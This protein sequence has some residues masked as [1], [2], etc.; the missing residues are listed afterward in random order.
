MVNVFFNNSTMELENK[1]SPLLVAFGIPTVD[2]SFLVGDRGEVDKYGLNIDSQR[3]MS[4]DVLNSIRNDFY[5]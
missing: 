4:Y 1:K 5:K 3:E 2:Y